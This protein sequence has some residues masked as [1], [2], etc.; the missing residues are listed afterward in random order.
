M[1]YTVVLLREDDGR[2][3][4]F[5]PALSGCYTW[6]ETLPHALRM[7]VE[8]MA[9]HLASLADHGDPIPDD[10]STFALNLED[11]VEAVIHRVEVR[12]PHAAE[13]TSVA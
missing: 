5:V 6:G 7:A 1:T 10:V 9:L 2:Y 3:S 11:A 13:A 8:A 12:A 4:V